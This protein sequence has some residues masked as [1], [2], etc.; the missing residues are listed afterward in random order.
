MKEAEDQSQ[1]HKL[2]TAVERILSD[3]DSLIALAEKHLSKARGDKRDAA[4][5][6]VRYFSNRAAVSGGLAAA[7]ALIPG[8]GTLAAALGG[9][10]ADMGFLLK[11]E[12]E[13]ALVLSYLHG[14][15]IRKDEERQ[16][17]FL[18][19]S[20]STYDAKSGENVLVDMAKAEGV[21]IWKYA[22]REVSKHL[23]GVM[24]KIALLQLSRGLVRALP[25]I[26]IAVG[27]SMN[28]VLT[29]RV[30][31]RCIQDL[32]K[33]REFLATESTRQEQE[34][35]VVE[36]RV[37][38]PAKKRAASKKSARAPARRTSGRKS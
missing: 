9:A 38:P 33:R 32:Q 27:S 29:T 34:E 19:A 22:P 1:G 17:A 15:D 12:V 18:L 13:M 5:E 24:T 8:A 26:G 4:G 11:Y 28:K 23:V 16:L 36:A 25:L 30:G 35:E 31:E 2:L 6:V 37:R 3:T 14:F 7:P 21:A 20:V 10:L